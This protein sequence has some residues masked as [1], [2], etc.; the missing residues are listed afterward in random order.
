MY[1]FY[2]LCWIG[3]S[4]LCFEDIYVAFSIV[5]QVTAH[6]ISP[7][8]ALLSFLKLIRKKPDTMKKYNLTFFLF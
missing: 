4:K 3:N 2:L 8:P 7:D 1:L 5:T 6:W